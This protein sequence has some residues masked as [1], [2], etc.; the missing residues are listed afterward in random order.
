M[1]KIMY[2]SNLRIQHCCDWFHYI[3][4]RRIENFPGGVKCVFTY[5]QLIW[6]AL[7]HVNV[8]QRRLLYNRGMSGVVITIYLRNQLRISPYEGEP[9]I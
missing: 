3:Y 2:F 1:H 8:F 5:A 4:I 7:H 9:H 6:P